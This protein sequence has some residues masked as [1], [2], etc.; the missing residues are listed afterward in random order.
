MPT[1]LVNLRNSVQ[2]P[3]EAAA[4]AA[5][6]AAHTKPGMKQIWAPRAAC[7]YVVAGMDCQNLG[8]CKC[9]QLCQDGA[10]CFVIMHAYILHCCC[11]ESAAGLTPADGRNRIYSRMWLECAVF[12]LCYV[13]LQGYPRLMIENRIYSSRV[14]RKL[15]LE[16]ATRQDGL[17]VMH[18]VLFPR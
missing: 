11:C 4:A 13:L 10:I 9:L 18:M 14:F 17:Q 16:I 7:A 8:V 2:E 12:V 5:A 6:S 1:A 15:H 3:T